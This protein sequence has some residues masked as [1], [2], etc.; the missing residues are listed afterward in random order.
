M[1]EISMN[2]IGILSDGMLLGGRSPSTLTIGCLV[3]WTCEVSVS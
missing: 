3:G 1:G 2:Y